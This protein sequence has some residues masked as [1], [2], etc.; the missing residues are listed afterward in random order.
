MSPG[1]PAYSRMASRN[2]RFLSPKA[3]YRLG[4]VIPIAAVS[5]ATD[6]VS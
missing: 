6:V 3:V 4:A 1:S 5:S 2:N